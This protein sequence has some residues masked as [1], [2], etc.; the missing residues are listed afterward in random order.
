MARDAGI[1]RRL[2]EWAQWL[3]VGDG[4]GYATKSTLHPEWSPP[5]PGMTPTLKVSAPSTARQTHRA[6]SLLS[7]RLANTLVLHYV[8]N[9][10]VV[11]QAE[12]LQCT[13]QT[14]EQ[15]I[16]TAHRKLLGLLS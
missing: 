1:E 14:I 16:W 9:L 2:Q 10:S 11:D 12:R 13:P 4:S 7:V 6:I 8:T 3:K 5:T 15:R